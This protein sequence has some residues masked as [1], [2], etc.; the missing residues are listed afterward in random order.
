MTLPYNGE[1][2]ACYYA[3]RGDEIRRRARERYRANR[4]RI[5]AREA[6]YR[7]RNPAWKRLREKKLEAI[8][9]FGAKCSRCGFDDWRALQFDHILGDGS[10]D[11]R[12]HRQNSFGYYDYIMKNPANF[13][14]LCSNCNWIKRFEQLEHTER[15][16]LEYKDAAARSSWSGALTARTHHDVSPGF[17]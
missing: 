10:K 12:L 11:R 9:Q 8:R 5:L 3:R 4:E 17:K 13:R 16:R 15:G 2:W 1:V 6:E 7:K 14:L